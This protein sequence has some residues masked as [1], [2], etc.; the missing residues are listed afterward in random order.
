MEIN[1]NKKLTWFDVDDMIKELKSSRKRNIVIKKDDLI[2]LLY[3]LKQYKSV[4]YVARHMIK[5]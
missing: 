2:Y 4:D 3:S 1:K 5:Y